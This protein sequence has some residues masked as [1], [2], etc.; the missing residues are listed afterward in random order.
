MRGP[1]TRSLIDRSLEPKGRPAH[2]ANGGEAPH[3]RAR[4][5]RSR[6]KIGVADVAGQGS[7]RRGAHQHRM[8]MRVDQPGHQHAPAPVDHLSVG[9]DRCNRN[10]LDPVAADQNIGRRGERAVFSVKNADVLEQY[11]GTLL[12]LRGWTDCQAHYN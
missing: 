5:F 12:S 8:P 2:V 9:R 1:G 4:R 3:Q 10:P 6:K 11:S 7:R